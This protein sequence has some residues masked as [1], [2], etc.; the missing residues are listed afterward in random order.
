MQLRKCWLCGKD[1]A[2]NILTGFSWIENDIPH[3][4]DR[5]G[6]NGERHY[7]DE[8][9]EKVKAENEHDRIEYIRLKKK[10]M[11]Q[12]ACRILEFQG[13]DMYKHRDAVE[14]V[15]NHIVLHPDKYDSADEVVAAIILVEN[16]IVTKMQY[17]IGK[18]QVDFLLPELGVVLEIDG[19]RHR[20]RKT[21]D[22]KRDAYIKQQL[23]YGWDIIRIKTDY[24]EKNA[25]QLVNAI[26]AVVEYRETNHIPWR[27]LS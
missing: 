9:F 5:I 19:E 16:R 14:V 18:Y 13:Y 26:N 15:E 4:D 24:I 21:Y 1:K 25:R 7:C 12:R 8:C 6:L 3:Y 11:F 2:Y 27:K 17:K 20:H 23:G 22:S 10:V